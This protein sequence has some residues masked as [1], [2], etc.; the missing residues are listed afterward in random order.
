M[1]FLLRISPTPTPVCAF[2]SLIFS[3][4]LMH[5]IP[6]ECMQ[7]L[8]C[9]FAK[10]QMVIEVM[11]VITILFLSKQ[12][13]PNFLSIIFYRICHRLLPTLATSWVSSDNMTL[14][15]VYLYSDCIILRKKGTTV[16]SVFL[17]AS[18]AFDRTNHKLLFVKLILSA[19]YLC[20]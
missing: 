7:T 19:M 3:M 12:L 9:L 15:C 16:F 11:L 2:I 1:K 8:M 17:D 5:G 18:K 10:I 6:Q 4:V 14:I 13:S 20:A